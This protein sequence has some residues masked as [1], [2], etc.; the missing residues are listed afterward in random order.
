MNGFV[1]RLAR[2]ALVAAAA[3]LAAGCGGGDSAED[4]NGAALDANVMLEQPANDASA[5]ES[6]YNAAEPAADS[7]EP[8]NAADADEADEAAGPTGPAGE[9]SGGDTGGNTLDSN[10]AAM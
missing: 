6:A 5:M 2:T 9:T 10:V 3:S 8:A 1:S 4:S 7:P